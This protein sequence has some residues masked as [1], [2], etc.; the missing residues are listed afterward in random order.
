MA[1]AL[2]PKL[3]DGA[4]FGNEIV[5]Q[6]TVVEISDTFKLYV[7][8]IQQATNNQFVNKATGFETDRYKKNDADKISIDI[9][10]AGNIPH[11]LEDALKVLAQSMNGAGMI[12]Q[13]LDDWVNG[14]VLQ[15]VTYDCRWVNAGD[16]VNSSTL[17]SG[18]TMQLLAFNVSPP[19]VIEEYQ[20]VIDIPA[21]TLEW[22]Y[23]INSGPGI[24]EYQRVIG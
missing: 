16:F 12:L 22:I 20:K 3:P 15:P 11:W 14:T 17:L 4:V 8:S 18:A 6:S 23:N 1:W 7:I 13:F 2:K 10:L 19:V 9:T 5:Y 24:T 21:S